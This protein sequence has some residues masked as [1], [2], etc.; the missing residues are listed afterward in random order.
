MNHYFTLLT[1]IAFIIKN[2]Y[3]KTV[4]LNSYIFFSKIQQNSFKKTY[5]KTIL[6]QN[7][8]K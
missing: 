2:P 1:H 8:T 6:K 5:N 3:Q 4:Q 7:R